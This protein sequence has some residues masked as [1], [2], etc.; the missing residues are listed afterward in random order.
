MTNAGVEIAASF[1]QL[2]RQ[3]LTSMV[4]LNLTAPLLLTH[5][6]LPGM[7]ERHRGH[8]VFVSSEAGKFGPAYQA[9]YAVTKAALIG[10]NQSLRADYAAAPIGFSVLCPGFIAG[11]GM[12]QRMVGEG[13]RSNRL[14][15]ETTVE[16]AATK[17][18]EAI[19]GDLPE[20][21]ET[22]A[23]IR[24]SLHSTNWRLGLSSVLCRCSASPSSSSSL[25]PN[26]AASN[27]TGDTQVG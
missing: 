25:P 20:I 22:G 3:E 11:D 24:R 9:P 1:T 2:T 23:P 16:K 18:L 12:Y 8:V 14:L 10:L 21:V 27:N 6:V 15:G 7:L 4:N 5:R 26:V 13:A 17:V 19:Q